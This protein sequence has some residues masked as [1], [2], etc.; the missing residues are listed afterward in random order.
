MSIETKLPTSIFVEIREYFDKSNGNSYFSA[1]IHID[2]EV[3]FTMP[4]E[5]GY[6]DHG[7]HQA[8]KEIVK[9]GYLP[10]LE[11]YKAFT[12][13]LRDLGVIYYSTKCKVLKRELFK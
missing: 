2:G 11:P 6:G 4:M 10:E 12:W 1:R 13:A 9:R 8:M 5:Y 3:V 7:Q